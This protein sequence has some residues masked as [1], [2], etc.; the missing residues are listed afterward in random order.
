M[1]IQLFGV[2]AILVSLPIIIACSLEIEVYRPQ[3]L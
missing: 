2:L 3:T 1:M